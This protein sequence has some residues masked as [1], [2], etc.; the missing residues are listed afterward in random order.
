MAHYKAPPTLGDNTDMCYENWKKEVQIWQLFTSLEKKKQAP[1]IFL[2]LT[3]Q[4]REA[5]LEMELEVLSS[6]DGVKEL[7]KK[8]DSLYL[9]DS[10]HSAYEAYEKFEKFCRP[11]SMTMND[12]IIEFERLYNKLKNYDMELPEG[13]LAYRFINSSNISESHKQL[14]RATLTELKYTKAKEQ[15]KRFL[16]IL[17]IL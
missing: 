14:I 1:A 3:G 7:V 17:Q 8:L 13:V 11:S 10:H 9:K 12:Y 15:L 5:I 2:T 4:A 6:D 16:V